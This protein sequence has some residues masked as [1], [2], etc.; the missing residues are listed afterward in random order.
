MYVVTKENNSLYVINLADKII[1][2]QLSLDNEAFAPV[3]T[4]FL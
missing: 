4:S 3:Q 1:I 2:Q